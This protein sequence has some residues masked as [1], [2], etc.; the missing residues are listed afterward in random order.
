MQV[1][2]VHR[3]LSRARTVTVTP[4]VIAGTGVALL[5]SI[6]LIAFGLY[7]VTFKI[8]FDQRVP[9]LHQFVEALVQGEVDR[10]EQHF[11]DNIDAMARK[12]GEM[13]ARLLRLD[14]LGERVAKLAGIRPE[15]FNFAEV[16]ARGGPAPSVGTQPTSLEQL[17]SEM[18]RTSKTVESRSD[19]MDVVE[20]EL[21]NAQVRRALLPQGTPVTTGF[22]GS[23]FG[24]RIDPFTGK[25]AMHSGIDFAAPTGTPI[26]AAAGGVV[27]ASEVHPEYGNMVEI[28]HGNGLSTLYGHASR[29][30][31]KAGDIVRRG[32]KIAEVGTTGRSTGPHVHFEVHVNGVPQNPS[33]FLATQRPDSPLAG[34]SPRAGAGGATAPTAAPAVPAIAAPAP[35]AA[36]K[37]PTNVRVASSL[38]PSTTAGTAAGG[39]ANPTAS[40]SAVAPPPS[41]APPPAT[42]A[43]APEPSAPPP[44]APAASPA[45]E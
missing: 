11:R 26:Y 36:A 4:Q 14:A 9:V 8:G 17:Q 30:V 7:A 5:S 45:A 23:G 13:Q 34:L 33:R 12:L 32:Q 27:S 19:Y 1:I 31:V 6:I 10:H 28:D 20:S 25:M 24:M 18:G 37:P 35:R 38:P 41:P 44:S 21:L 3:K 42:A 43:A 16:P 29:L 15:E 22:I 39:A 2:F 40:S